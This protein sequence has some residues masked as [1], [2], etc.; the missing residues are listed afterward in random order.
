MKQAI[1][2]LAGLF[3]ILL[4]QKTTAQKIQFAGNLGTKKMPVAE[5]ATAPVLKGAKGKAATGLVLKKPAKAMLN[6]SKK[7]TAK[8]VKLTVSKKYRNKPGAPDSLINAVKGKLEFPFLI[9]SISQEYGH[10]KKGTYTLFNP[11]ITFVSAA[12]V[13]ARSCYDAVVE[14][15]VEVEGMYVVIASCQKI[16]FGYSNLQEVFVQKG[17]SITTGAPVGIVSM[18]ETGSYSLLFLL[19]VSQKETNPQYWF[20]KSP[21]QLQEK[22]EWE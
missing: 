20:N 7:T 5:T 22:K 11:G 17:D 8:V 10:K 3:A 2:L 15:V 21:G 9:C 1:I 6:P 14:N 19:Q 18:D 16:Y 13:T 4:V 12:P